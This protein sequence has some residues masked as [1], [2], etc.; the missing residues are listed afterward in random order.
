M[1]R[2]TRRPKTTRKA[3]AIS[4]EELVRTARNRLREFSG[5]ELLQLHN[6]LEHLLNSDSPSKAELERLKRLLK[7]SS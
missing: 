4:T 5:P 2:A 6:L 7:Q 1:A 3:S